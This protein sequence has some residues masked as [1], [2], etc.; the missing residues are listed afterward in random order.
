[1]SHNP[2]RKRVN[3]EPMKKKNSK[4]PRIIVS[5]HHEMLSEH[6]VTDKKVLIGRSDF[7]D[8]VIED[9]F[10]SKLH[11]MLLVYSDALV[12][13]DLNSA[14]G[15]TVNSVKTQCALLKDDDIITIGHHRMKVENAPALSDEM[16]RL[17][18]TKDTL[19]MKSIVDVQRLKETQRRL[20]AI[21]NGTPI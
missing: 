19:K 9:L 14:N 2:F 3:T 13:L 11:A 15:L 18:E 4:T 21:Q 1:M 12:L 6:T 10:A 16:R 17:L 7:A 8:I 5:R 20:V